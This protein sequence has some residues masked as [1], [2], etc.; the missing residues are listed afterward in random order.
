MLILFDSN[1][2]LRWQEP[3]HPDQILVA[4]AVD[5]LLL[6]GAV[7]CFTSQ[8]LGEFWNV[9]TRPIDRNGYGLTPAQADRRASTIE[10][11]IDLLPDT[12]DV[13]RQWRRLLVVHRV[14][15]V[16]VHDARLVAA[17]HV[18]SVKRILTFNTK[19]FMRFTDIEAIHPL[20]LS[21]QVPAE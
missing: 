3:D 12:P 20:D 7:P 1:I 16:Q 11:R 5:R 17:M 13:H 4:S 6:S 21:K 10:S 14:S 9:L 2:L 15:G 19:D 8:N 18:H